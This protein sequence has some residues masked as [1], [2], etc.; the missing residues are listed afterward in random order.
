M[1]NG[2]VDQIHGATALVSR[3]VKGGRFHFLFDELEHGGVGSNLRHSR[4]AWP[5]L[6]RLVPLVG[7][8]A[9]DQ[10][11]DQVDDDDHVEQQAAYL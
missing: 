5:R 1:A 4:R 11:D 3:R 9:P 10:A 7:A 6:V 2:W 8:T